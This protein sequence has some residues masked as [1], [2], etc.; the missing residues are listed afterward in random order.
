MSRKCKL[1]TRKIREAAGEDVGPTGDMDLVDHLSVHT[2][3][4]PCKGQNHVCLCSAKR[5]SPTQPNWKGVDPLSC[6]RWDRRIPAHVDKPTEARLGHSTHI[7]R[8][9]RQTA[10]RYGSSTSW[11]YGISSVDSTEAS[12]ARNRSCTSGC[13]ARRWKVRDRAFEVVSI[14]ANTR[15]LWDP[16]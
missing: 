16:T 12:S 1:L 9:S 6:E 4:R 14:V 8:V 5:F 3:N 13:C 2:P 15:V 10:S 7:L 11:S